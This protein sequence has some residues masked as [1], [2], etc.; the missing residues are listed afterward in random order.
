MNSGVLV[1]VAAGPEEI[2]SAE[3]ALR[4]HAATALHR[5]RVGPHRVL[6]YGGFSGDR[7]A[8]VAV[9]ALRADGWPAVARPLSG[10]HLTVWQKHT[11][12]VA[13]DG[14][15]QICFP[16][17]EASRQVGPPIVEI[18]PGRGFGTGSH[19]TTR[20][21]LRQLVSRLQPGDSVLDVGSGSGVLAVVAA[22]LGASQVTAVDI[23]PEALLAS[24]RNA[25]RNGVA[26]R[27]RVTE[28]PLAELPVRY[29]VVLANI[30]CQVLVELADAIVQRLRPGGW[31]GLSGLSPSQ[32][33][34]VQAAYRPLAVVEEC[35]D[36]DW[37]ALILRHSV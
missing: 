33:S 3:A 21:V 24:R 20:L 10:G 26:D 27:V 19:P 6:V 8:A 32:I 30:A 11:S 4:R 15:V 18:D 28:A 2:E 16:W 34:V 12:P 31:L 23:H 36:D 17:S 29:D 7:A 14:R 37:V 1:V 5:R 22:R 9:D 25:A 35:R 13:I